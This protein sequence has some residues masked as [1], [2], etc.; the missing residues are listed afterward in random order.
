VLEAEMGKRQLEQLL[1]VLTG[2]PPWNHV[3]HPTDGL[4]DL[5]PLPDA[6]TS[7]QLVL[8]RPDLQAALARV[9]AADENVAMA[10]AERYPRLDLSA[11][12]STTSAGSASLFQDWVQS[13]SGQLVGPI[14]DGGARS[15]E[16][17]RRRAQLEASV[18]AFQV[19]SLEA[20]SEV[21]NAILKVR[22]A[23]ER[24]VS[25]ERRVRGQEL[26]VTQLRGR[27]LQGDSPYVELLIALRDF[28]QLRRR[29]VE[30]K[31]LAHQS[32]VELYAS[33]AGSIFSSTTFD[34][35]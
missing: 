17:D 8:N 23:G 30:A 29:H 16:V 10:I 2:R 21:E 1:T 26:I 4:G 12:I 31:G 7:S 32:H 35:E 20:F 19:A 33:L 34:H 28:K 18:K 9:R 11:A 15:A 27:V 25:F 24:I 13:L 22:R 5:P 3:F 6:G 14:L